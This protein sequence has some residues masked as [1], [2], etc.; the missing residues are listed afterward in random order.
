MY[1]GRQLIECVASRREAGVVRVDPAAGVDAAA[2][3]TVRTSMPL[4][5]LDGAQ[6][7]SGVSQA[8]HD[9]DRLALSEFRA[10]RAGR[11]RWQ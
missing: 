9:S 11:Q 7:D 5:L 3:G 6:E 2:G 8:D 4:R 10:L 1:G